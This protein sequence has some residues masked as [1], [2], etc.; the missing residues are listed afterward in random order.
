MTKVE[1]TYGRF[2]GKNMFYRMQV[3]HER[4]QDNYILFTNWGRIGDDYGTQHQTTP[5]PTAE[6][7]CAEFKKIFR[8]KS[9]NDWAARA[10][11]EKKP[12]K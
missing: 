3:I 12:K 11:F 2:G 1:L 10:S 7:A 8:E 4:N 6:A 5:F 9:G